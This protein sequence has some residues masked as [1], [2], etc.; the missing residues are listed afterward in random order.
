[1]HARCDWIWICIEFDYV[2]FILLKKKHGKVFVQKLLLAQDSIL[3]FF[4]QIKEVRKARNS[5]GAIVM[6]LASK[7]EINKE[8]TL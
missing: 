7:E 5:I 4:P 8:I 1:L 2:Q 6:H 3:E